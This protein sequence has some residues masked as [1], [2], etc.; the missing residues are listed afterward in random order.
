MKQAILI[1]AY[2]NEKQIY[3]IINYFGSDFEF[4]IH[5]D[6]K[7]SINLSEYW[8]RRNVNVYK[9]FITNYGSVNHLR[10]ILFL[11]KEALKK[12]NN[13]YF[14]LIT[15]QDFPVKT[16]DY[17]S[18]E[19]NTGKDYLEYFEMPSKSWPHGGM[20]RIEYYNFYDFLDCKKIIYVRFIHMFLKIQKLL[21]I[22]RKRTLG[23]F[24]KKLYGGS[25]YWSLTRDSLQYVVNSTNENIMNSMKYT[26]CAEEIYFQTVL[27]NST[28][29][30]N[31]VNDN[32]R[33]IVWNRDNGGSPAYLDETDYCK[34][35]SSNKIFARKFHERKSEKL[36]AQLLTEVKCGD[37]CHFGS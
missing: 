31:I 36:K 8:D 11:S 14:H 32:L 19:L 2:K 3:D 18:D 27:L 28:F 21:K 9:I 37:K 6:K 1:T 30:E 10:A 34:I 4:Y 5:I 35:K 26:Y 29:A 17:F 22:K 24:F 15:G 16:K 23:G 13:G 20:D 25:T 33:Y 7:S 12:N